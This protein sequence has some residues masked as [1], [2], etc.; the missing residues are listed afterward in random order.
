[1]ADMYHM[2]PQSSELDS[3]QA[4]CRGE[5]KINKHQLQLKV[6]WKLSHVAS[7]SLSPVIKCFPW[8]HKAGGKIKLSAY[9][10]KKQIERK[11]AVVNIYGNFL[12][13]MHLKRKEHLEKQGRQHNEALCKQK[14]TSFSICF[15]HIFDFTF[16]L[17]LAFNSL[18][19]GKVIVGQCVRHW[20]L[21]LLNVINNLI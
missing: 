14:A 9:K 15:K 16:F 12:V 11:N 18:I 13:P 7:F 1:M 3:H 21:N 20:E 17:H 4:M 6:C 10:H 5:R 8:A 19:N 2:L